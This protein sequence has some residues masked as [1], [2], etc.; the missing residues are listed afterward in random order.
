MTDEPHE[1]DGPAPGP[2]SHGAKLRYPREGQGVEFDRVANFTDAVFAIALTL[3][4]VELHPPPL[5]VEDDPIELLHSLGEMGDELII[6]FVAFAVMGSYWLANH[7]FVAGLRG[8]DSSYVSWVLPYLAMVAFLPFPADMMGRYFD[9]PVAVSFFA[10]NMAAV[11]FLEWLLL[12]RAHVGDLLIH[13][14]A[15]EAY[16]WAS[17]GALAPVPV[18]LA[19]VPVMW[20]DTRLGLATWALNAPIGIYLNRRAP[21]LGEPGVDHRDGETAGGAAD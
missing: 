16:R 1:G 6:F 20:I 13:P 21:G 7:R 15:P 12:W 9:N 10:V 8:M 17:I 3:I 18:F 2:L 14:L 19:S 4:A 11:S 5:D